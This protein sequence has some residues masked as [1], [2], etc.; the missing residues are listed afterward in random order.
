[1]V[2]YY[3]VNAGGNMNVAGTWST[4]ANKDASRVGGAVVPGTTSDCILDDYSGSVTMAAAQ[5]LKTLD[6]TTNGNYAGTLDFGTRVLTI[7]GTKL[8][9][10]STMTLNSTSDAAQIKFTAN[11]TLTSGGLAIPTGLRISGMSTLTLA[12]NAA[13]TYDATIDNSLALAGNFNWGCRNMYVGMNPPGLAMTIT[14]KSSQ[15]LTV[16]TTLKVENQGPYAIE[17]KSSTPGTQ[18]N[19]A[20][21]GAE[22]QLFCAKFT[23]INSDVPIYLW[24]GDAASAGNT[25]VTVV[26]DADIGGGSGSS[27]FVIL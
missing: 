3:G 6:C 13:F 8:V 17:V 22:A 18:A 16:S 26:T 12:G 2:T 27:G 15:T 21:T 5:T 1:M 4:I 20:T 9:F 7:S 14:L 19:L 23:D 25:N 11:A 10:A 24:Y